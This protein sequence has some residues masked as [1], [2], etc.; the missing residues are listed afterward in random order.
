MIEA[1]NEDL[2]RGFTQLAVELIALEQWTP[3]QQPVLHGAV[4]TGVIWQF[5]TLE[6]QTKQITKTLTCTAFCAD[7]MKGETGN[8][9][10]QF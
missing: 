3:S 10:W 1:K 6:R 5:G 9:S 7:L 2:Q 8:I 4:S